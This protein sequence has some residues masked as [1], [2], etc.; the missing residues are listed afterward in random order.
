MFEF[1]Y[2]QKIWLLFYILSS[3]LLEKFYNSQIIII[4]KIILYNNNKSNKK[5]DKI[6]YAFCKLHKSYIWLFNHFIDVK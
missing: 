2:V 4:K 1:Y 6:L 5:I 3:I